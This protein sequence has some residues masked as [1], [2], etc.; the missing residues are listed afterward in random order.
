MPVFR[1]TSARLTGQVREGEMEAASSAAVVQR[2]RADEQ[3]PIRIEQ[4]GAAR[5]PGRRLLAVLNRPLFD[6]RV[7]AGEVADL[8][9]ELAALVGAG[10]TLDRALSV[11]AEA[12]ARAK[13]RALV[14]RLRDRVVGGAP[15]SAAMEAEAP[16]F[17]RFA[18]A[19]VRAGEA[20]GQLDGALERLAG[21]MARQ[22]AVGES[23]KSALVYPAILLAVAALSV[24][25]LLVFVLP[26]FEVI[27]RQAGADLPVATAV[28]LGLA[29]VVRGY[30]WLG[31]LG[32]IAV[33]LG[34]RAAL[35]DPA[36]RL[37]W[38][39]RVARLPLAGPLAV[40][41]SV[42]RTARALAL[43]L[44][45]GVALPVALEIAAEAAGNRAVAAAFAAAAQRVRDGQALAPSLG[46]SGLIPAKAVELV[47]V[48][49]QTGRL[50]D[51]LATVASLYAREVEV[52]L[53]RLVVVIEPVLILFL[54]VLVAGMIFPV[55]AAVVGLNELAL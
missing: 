14:H 35:R 36:A 43:L 22:R 11:V 42:E 37:A 17:G 34:A 19:A 2:L 6:A 33:W 28:V 51:M 41:L 44:K 10:L 15:L 53:K 50:D 20:S 30:G 45:H 13:T 23:V 4:G 52:A 24:V 27:F 29:G 1:Y 16:V 49:E 25:L 31:L 8:V 12:G 26:R 47:A 54:G 48:G 40:R 5:R 38:D 55:L 21:E 39:R 18:I 9:A 3:F 46:E 7:A 32:M